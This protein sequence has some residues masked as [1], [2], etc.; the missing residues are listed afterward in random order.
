MNK[1]SRG[2]KTTYDEVAAAILSLRSEGFDNPSIARITNHIAQASGKGSSTATISKFKAQFIQAELT[3]SLPGTLEAPADPLSQKAFDLW[4]EMLDGIRARELSMEAAVNRRAKE[5]E[6]KLFDNEAVIQQLK[7]EIT[8]KDK[9]I[10]ESHA[11][12]KE[13]LNSKDVEITL[14]EKSV[15][16]VQNQFV[17]SDNELASERKSREDKETELNKTIASLADA[18]AADREMHSLKIQE[19]L[20]ASEKRIADVQSEASAIKA[21]LQ[22]EL[23]AKDTAFSSL[24]GQAERTQQAHR[25]LE[26]ANN[27]LTQQHNDCEQHAQE[28]AGL[29]TRLEKQLESKECQLTEILEEQRK[30]F[31]EIAASNKDALDDY[32]QRLEEKQSELFECRRALDKLQP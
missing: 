32:A 5:I 9:E 11:D 23:K 13:R 14:L 12:I 6:Q 10:V 29:I 28:K 2:P 1:K 4:N 19:T 22:S 25:K 16:A 20:S 27:L 17:R 26:D 21:R 18:R 7:E 30:E 24:Q 15:A 31:R 8:E 3:E